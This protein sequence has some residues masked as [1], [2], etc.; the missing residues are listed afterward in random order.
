MNVLVL[1]IGG[2]S[3][4][5]AVMNEQREIIER[6]KR[7]T[8]LSDMDALFD[9]FKEIYEGYGKG[10][11]G[12]AIS[13]P[14]VIDSEHGYAYTAGALR[15][16]KNRAFAKEVSQ[17]FHC[18]VWIGNDA[19]CAGI[20]EVGY[21][22]L[23]GVED[24]IVIILGTGIGGCLIK[25]GKVHQGKHFCSGEVSSLHLDYKIT[26]G[27]K[28]NWWRINGI[29]GLLETAQKHLQ[30]DMPMSGEEIFALAH[31][32]NEQALT[33][34]HEFSDRIALQLFNIQAT[35]DAE[36]IAIGGGISAQDLLIECIQESFEQICVDEP[37]VMPQIVACQFR[38][39]A[40]LIGAY[41]QFI[42]AYEKSC[43]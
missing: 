14:G 26:R 36:K 29:Q 23:Q 40:N 22:A 17:L 43:L 20:A 35:Y 34:I 24:A 25:D 3:I 41:Y 38:N 8:P 10:V 42:K 39:D 37:V 5:I 6:G 32:G 4:K 9:C 31:A 18:P 12:I 2:S 33:A 27:D 19:K 13:M 28:A 30:S 7:E 1:D 21:G 15:Y 11:G 16:L